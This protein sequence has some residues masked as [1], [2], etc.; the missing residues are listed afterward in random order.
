MGMRRALI[1]ATAAALAVTA[2]RSGHEQPVYPSYYPHEIEIAAMAPQRAAELMRAG[3][4]Q[5]YVGDAGQSAF[6]ASDKIGTVESLGA[7]VIVRLNPDSDFA[8]DRSLGLR[9]R[10]RARARH[11]WQ[12]QRLDRP[13]LPGDALPRRLPRPCRSRRGRPAA[14]S[15]CAPVHRRHQGSRDRRPAKPRS[16]G[17]VDRWHQLGCRGRGGQ[18]LR[19]SLPRAPCR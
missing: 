10:G 7:F 17:L 6:A 8:K 11:E 9:R 12:G 1:L 3:K 4:L 15:G 14:S 13:P 18:R 16:P 19:L 5:A 2:A